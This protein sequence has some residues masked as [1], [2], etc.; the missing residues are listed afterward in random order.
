MAQSSEVMTLIQALLDRIGDSLERLAE[1]S[2]EDLD[3]PCTHPCAT[4]G[5]GGGTTAAGA[6]ATIVAPGEPVPGA[7]AGAVVACG[8]TRL[9]TCAAAKPGNKNSPSTAIK[10][11]A[12]PAATALRLKPLN[13]PPP[14]GFFSGPIAAISSHTPPRRLRSPVQPL[15]KLPPRS[16]YLG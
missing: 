2:D 6:G 8:P 13:P 12:T 14:I 3:E 10:P 9:C 15:A 7:C 1:L 4:G 11:A 5:T 16:P